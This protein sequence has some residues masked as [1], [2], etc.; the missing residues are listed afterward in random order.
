MIDDR[1][2]L[3][4]TARVGS[5][6]LPGKVLMQ[7]WN[8]FSLLEFLIERLRSRF[9]TSKIILATA[10][11]KE[12]DLIEDIGFKCDIPVVRGPESNVLQRMNLCLDNY[13]NTEYIGRVT[14]DNPF[15]DPELI[16]M[17]LEEMKKSAADYSYCRNVPVGSA[18]DLWTYDCFKRTVNEATSNYEKEHVNAWAW[19]NQDRIKVLWYNRF[20][21]KTASKI[22]LSVDTIEQFVEV[23]RI[24][25]ILDDPINASLDE[26]E[27]KLEAVKEG[28]K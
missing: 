15:T 22:N 24:T 7:F 9:K 12:N 13:L 20:S 10:F 26:I 17:Q 28:K 19:N 8:E 21:M 16:E 25:R 1:P 6:R 27:C 14:A 23:K 3:I 18:A 2:L 5:T 11:S 4:I